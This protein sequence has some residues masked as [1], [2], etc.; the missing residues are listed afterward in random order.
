MLKLYSLNLMSLILLA[1][2][3]M[4]ACSTAEAIISAVYLLARINSNK[5]LKASRNKL[6]TLL[7]SYWLYIIFFVVVFSLPVIGIMNKY[8]D[9]FDF[10]EGFLISLRLLFKSGIAYSIFFCLLTLKY[11]T[12]LEG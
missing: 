10:L 8:I 3:T 11:V 4:A 2:I 6:L 7:L 12:L 1:F 5:T 9:P